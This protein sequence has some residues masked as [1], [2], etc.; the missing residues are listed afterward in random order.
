M[1]QRH[2]VYYYLFFLPIPYSVVMYERFRYSKNIL[3]VI[4]TIIPRKRSCIGKFTVCVRNL[5]LKKIYTR[6]INTDTKVGDAALNYEIISNYLT[7]VSSI[8]RTMGNLKP[9]RNVF[10]RTFNRFYFKE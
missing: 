1:F 5:P 8:E 6:S 9:T 4:I 7:H 2:F 3:H 10:S